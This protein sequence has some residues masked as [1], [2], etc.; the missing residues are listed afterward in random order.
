MIRREQRG[1][2]LLIAQH[3]HALISGELAE[4]F[5]NDQF[6]KPMPYQQT[7]AGIRLHDCGWPLHD[8]EPTLNAQRV[9]LDVFETPAAIALKVWAAGVE[10]AKTQDPYAGLLV[11]LHVLALSVMALDTVKDDDAK[12]KFALA[13]FQQ[14]QIEQQ[15]NLR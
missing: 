14:Q 1:E 4:Y 3:D 5:G 10:K 6:A 13:R 11:S 7:L 15:E 8:D 9:P 12:S 2:F